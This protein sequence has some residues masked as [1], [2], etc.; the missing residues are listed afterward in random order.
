MFK[1]GDL[2]KSGVVTVNDVT[3]AKKIFQKDENL[4]P[5]SLNILDV[6]KDSTFSI[7]DL[8]SVISSYKG[9]N[10]SSGTLE[11]RHGSD[12]TID[13]YLDLKDLREFDKIIGIQAYVSGVKLTSK[14]E[15]PFVETKEVILSNAIVATNTIKVKGVDGWNKDDLSIIYIELNSKEDQIDTTTEQKIKLC[16]LGYVALSE[17]TK[18]KFYYELPY[19][20]MIIGVIDDSIV[21]FSFPVKNF[22]F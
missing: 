13:L 22:E 4:T 11:L 21:E 20:S 1:Y 10:L 14:I 17:N 19:Q 7:R 5:D 16:T 8:A 3:K 12:N 18:V 15:D 2:S 6:N 9:K